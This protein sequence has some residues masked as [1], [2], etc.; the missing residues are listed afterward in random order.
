[1][2][3]KV[4]KEFSFD[5]AHML[6][7]HEGLCKNLHGHTY[8][9]E[10]TVKRPDNM[11]L[12]I[13]SGPAEGMIIDFKELKNIANELFDQLDHAF[14]YNKETKD[15]VEKTIAVLLEDNGRKTYAMDCRPTAEN[16]AHHFA[17]ELSS[18]LTA[19]FIHAE[20]SSVKVWETP[21][22]FAE[23]QFGGGK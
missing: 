10:V 8:K 22:S 7:G 16:M 13:P 12:T 11:A 21:T 17:T 14:V 3:I 5:C 6:A 15:P 9:I 1:M 23:F 19:R 20:I 4:T 2:P 18:A